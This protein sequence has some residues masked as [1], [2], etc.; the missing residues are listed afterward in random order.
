MYP[1]RT[2]SQLKN[3]YN[4]LKFTVCRDFLLSPCNPFHPKRAN[5]FILSFPPFFSLSSPHPTSSILQN[6]SNLL[7]FFSPSSRIFSCQK[8]CIKENQKYETLASSNS[9]G[10]GKALWLLAFCLILEC[11]FLPFQSKKK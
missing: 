5:F 4:P 6:W 9:S 7:S 2:Q 11:F 3:P 1:N 10:F 8:R